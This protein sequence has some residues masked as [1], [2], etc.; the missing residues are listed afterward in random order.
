MNSEYGLLE[1]L[2]L[3]SEL[4]VK[5][6]K[7][8]AIVFPIGIVIRKLSPM[9]FIYLVSILTTLSLFSLGLLMI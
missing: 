8:F 5:L 6:I 7:F 3:G 9:I 1:D 4:F 2:F